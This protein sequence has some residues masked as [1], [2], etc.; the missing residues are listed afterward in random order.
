MAQPDGR[1]SGRLRPT[2]LTVLAAALLASCSSGGSASSV[3]SA[4]ASSGSPTPI[5]SAAASHAGRLLTAAQAKAAL[6]QVSDLP[7]NWTAAPSSAQQGLDQLLP[8]GPAV[9]TQP[10]RCASVLQQLDEASSRP[11]DASAGAVFLGGLTGPFLAVLVKSYAAGGTGEIVSGARSAW[12]SCPSFTIED[13]SGTTTVA[14]SDLTFPAL[15]DAR[16]ATQIS[17]DEA[18]ST[19]WVTLAAVAVGNTLVTVTEL[20]VDGAP[21]PAAVQAA[22]RAVL[23]RLAAG[24]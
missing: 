4:G 8:S 24:S 9:K 13:S 14:L 3:S 7:G 15:G 21:D 18:G 22:A 16:Y 12:T 5:S 23:D 20:Q 2:V 1:R 6:P 17:L 10:A 19:G 11:A